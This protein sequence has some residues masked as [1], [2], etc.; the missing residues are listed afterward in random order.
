MTKKDYERLALAFQAAVDA[1]F[2]VENVSTGGWAR[3]GINIAIRH[4]ADALASDNPRFDRDRFVLACQSGA[5]VRAKSRAN[6]GAPRSA[7]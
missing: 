3:Y 1:S 2:T 5:N 6:Q 7:A 4:V